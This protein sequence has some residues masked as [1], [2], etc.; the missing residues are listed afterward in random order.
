MI[1]SFCNF[2]RLLVTKLRFD[3]DPALPGREYNMSYICGGG[4]SSKKMDGSLDRGVIQVVQLSQTGKSDKAQ[5]KCS[6][7][8]F[9]LDLQICKSYNR[10]N[11]PAAMNQLTFIWSLT[12]TDAG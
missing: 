3:C 5:S 6:C 2:L 12:R 8:F 10:N 9:L 11:I 1:T 4:T 7:N